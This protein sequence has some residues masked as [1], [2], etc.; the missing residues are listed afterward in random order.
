MQPPSI[1]FLRHCVESYILARARHKD[2]RQPEG[3]LI[4]TAAT[5]R[6]RSQHCLSPRR[7][8]RRYQSRLYGLHYFRCQIS[9][10]KLQGMKFLHQKDCRE[11]TQ[12]S[13]QSPASV[14]FK[15]QLPCSRG[16]ITASQ[17]SG[18]L[19]IFNAFQRQ[20]SLLLLF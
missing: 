4:P 1:L 20:G 10:Q 11:Y 2:Q 14:L 6:P 5:Q 3:N 13:A 16:G 19:R 12:M 18:R 7:A 9:V 8:S 15:F 17:F